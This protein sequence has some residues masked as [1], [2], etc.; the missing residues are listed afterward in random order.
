MGR[1]VDDALDRPRAEPADERPMSGSVVGEAPA[2]AVRQPMDLEMVF[3][4]IDTDG[5]RGH[6]FHV[7]CLSSEPVYSG[8]RSGLTEKTGAILL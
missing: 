6:L 7:L 5:K 8:I 2:G 4:N 1:L 3:R